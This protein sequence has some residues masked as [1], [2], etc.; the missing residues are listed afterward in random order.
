VVVWNDESLGSE[1]HSLDAHNVPPE[2]AFVDA[3]EFADVAESVG[4][5]GYT[6]RSLDDLRALSDTLAADPDGPVVIDCKVN[7]YVRHRSKM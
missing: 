1:Y 2:V 4:A 6:V 5:A 7:P 3:P